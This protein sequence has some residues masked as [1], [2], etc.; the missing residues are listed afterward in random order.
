MLMCVPIRNDASEKWIHRRQLK[1]IPLEISMRTRPTVNHTSR[2][3]HPVP[4]IADTISTAFRIESTSDA[5]TIRMPT[6]RGDRPHS[7]RNLIRVQTAS[8]RNERNEM[9]RK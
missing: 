6:I 3:S 5:S 4:R 1:T 8:L 2:C 7:L 9:N